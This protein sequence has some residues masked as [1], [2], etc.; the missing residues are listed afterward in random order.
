MQLVQCCSQSNKLLSFLLPEYDLPLIITGEHGAACTVEAHI[1]NSVR[2]AV[3][4]QLLSVKGGGSE[5]GI[6][7]W[8][9]AT[10]CVP[11]ST[12]LSEPSPQAQASTDPSGG[13][14]EMVVA[15]AAVHKLTSSV[16]CY[17]ADGVR[18]KVPGGDG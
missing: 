5:G 2:V 1:K 14:R 6:D 3:H 12:V 16:Y 7:R 13:G 17:R 15:G 9:K 8:R 4:H 11:S 18:P 10:L